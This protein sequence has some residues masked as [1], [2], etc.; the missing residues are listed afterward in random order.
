MLAPLHVCD[1]SL[2]QDSEAMWL[3]CV[4][5]TSHPMILASFD[6]LTC[7]RDTTG[8]CKVMMSS[9]T[10]LPTSKKSNIL[11]W[12]KSLASALLDTENT[13]ASF[14]TSVLASIA[15]LLL[16]LSSGVVVVLCLTWDPSKACVYVH[17]DIPV[18][19]LKKFLL[20]YPSFFQA[21]NQTFIQ[22]VVSTSNESW[23]L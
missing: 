17:L 5:T 6:G 7:I 15:W 16:L 10:V 23:C 12:M 4:S 13:W 14:V 8:S 3:S 18:S 11:K 20:V 9:H 1:K 19:L 21:R 2:G 22:K